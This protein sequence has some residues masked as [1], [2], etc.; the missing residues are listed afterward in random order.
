MSSRRTSGTGLNAAR[1]HDAGISQPAGALGRV[2][3]DGQVHAHPRVRAVELAIEL[4]AVEGGEDLGGDG[5]IDEEDNVCDARA[6]DKVSQR[7]LF[8]PGSILVAQ[9]AAVTQREPISGLPATF[10]ALCAPSSER[11]ET[12]GS[13]VCVT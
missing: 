7:C 11:T 6:D 12:S 4:L 3:V 10:S 13:T 1:T 2:A 5:G 8:G 9:N